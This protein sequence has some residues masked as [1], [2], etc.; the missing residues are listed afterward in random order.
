MKNQT[1]MI[2]LTL[3][4]G[5]FVN[6]LFAK[7]DV[8]VK[9]SNSNRLELQINSQDFSFK[10]S[11]YPD[12]QSYLKI[13]PNTGQLL[14][15]QPDLPQSGRW[16]IV[17]NGAEIALSW[18]KKSEPLIYDNISLAPVQPQ[19][20]DKSEAEIPPFTI[21]R[22]LYSRNS[23]FP[24]KIAHIERRVIKNG[25]EYALL[26]ISPFQYNP[27][28]KILKFYP[29]LEL[30]ID[31]V[32]GEKAQIVADKFASTLNNNIAISKDQQRRTDRQTG[33]DMLIVT[34]TEFALAAENLANWK[35]Q[36]GLKTL[37]VTTSEIGHTASA[38]ESY[39]DDSCATWDLVPGYLLLL[40]DAEFIPT[41]YVNEHPYSDGNQGF[42][43]ADI[44]YADLQDDLIADMAYGRIP[45]DTAAEADSVVAQIIRYEKDPPQEA[46]FYENAI[47]AAYFQEQDGGNGIAERR[48]A[49]TA[50]DFR[51]FLQTE[52]S[53]SVERIYVTDN[54][55]DPLYWNDGP[56]VFEN[57]EA[58]EPL[59]PEL[60]RPFFAWDGDY[61]AISS[62]VNLGKFMLL[63][64]DH[65][66]RQGW[67]DPY[68][69]VNN[70]SQLSN[71]DLPPIVWSINCET[72]WFDNETDAPSCGTANSSESFTEAWLRHLTAGS[73]GVFAATRVSYSGNNDRLVWG[74]L[75]A[76]WPQ[77][78]NWTGADYPQHTGLSRMGDVM[79]YGKE[80]LM[81]SYTWGDDVLLATMEEFSYFGDP[82]MRMYTELPQTIVATHDP[83]ITFG[84]QEFLVEANVEGAL[85]TLVYQ[86]EIISSGYVE[87][88]EVLLELDVLED[89][90]QAILTLSGHNLR[91]YQADIFVEPEGAYLT[92][93]LNEIVEQGDYID[94][95]WQSWDILDF[96]IQLN[97]IGSESSGDLEL[98][99]LSNN[100]FVEILE[101]DATNTSLSPGSQSTIN[102]AFKVRLLE[103][104]AD[105]TQISLQ[106]QIENDQQQWTDQI[107]FLARAANLVQ[108]DYQLESDNANSVFSP[109]S[110]GEIYFQLQN[111][112]SGYAYDVE[113]A[114]ISENELVEIFGGEY[115]SSLAPGEV[116][117]SEQAFEIS[118]DQDFPIDTYLDV[119]Y[120]Q[121]DLAGLVFETENQI[122]I[123]VLL[124]DFETEND[125][126][127][128]ALTD[129]YGNQWHLSEIANI[130]IDGGKAYKFGSSETDNY[131]TLQHGALYTPEIQLDAGSFLRFW[132]KMNVGHQT[133]E[134]SWDGGLLE[135]SVEG[136]EFE[137]IYPISG[138]PNSLLNLPSSPF[139]ADTEFFSGHFD[140]RQV[141]FD[142][143]EY[144]GTAVV[145]FVFGSANMQTSEGWYIDDLRFGS[146]LVTSSQESQ[147]PPAEYRARNFPN[148]FVAASSS[149]RQGGTTIEFNLPDPQ[150]ELTKLTIF[151]L[152]GQVVKNFT[153]QVE[154]ARNTTY[155][156]AWAGDDQ[157]GKFVGSGIYFYK[158]SS[159][160][161]SS[162]HKMMM[163]K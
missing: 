5:L 24:A 138:Y 116:Y 124:Y 140:W 142:L 68:F 75:N 137:Q 63:H 95:S 70:V 36:L 147:T 150:S 123:G 61:A 103:G 13:L 37:V 31:F 41:H 128:E 162:I 19:R 141:E 83:V 120:T 30:Q 15:G 27:Q 132:H 64:R 97:N 129:G 53:Y 73:V 154:Q 85:A 127:S 99:L 65:G 56:Y 118:L 104:I 149:T 6:I 92:A 66:W 80:Y 28:T 94:N 69:N 16:I 43:A 161:F 88:G 60:Q 62:S 58:A 42:T 49:K 157:S 14:P 113:T 77:F 114:L 40:G 2:A 35:R 26:K 163:I 156:I 29:N 125:W 110:S 76:I 158:I 111:I 86:N 131:A 126:F 134:I 145:R 139:A 102:S 57:D 4:L 136:A 93:E 59:P 45:I 112:G 55:T 39:I 121:T 160:K 23:W 50:E 148:P 71:T 122:L 22:S 152:K 52:N 12:K 9:Q 82:A 7:T 17:P 91:T 108:T 133:N 67:G 146:T 1:K 155:R 117:S 101:A 38:I 90:G 87:S 106:V 25:Q 119:Q 143:S 44:Y 51:N 96:D 21:D 100:D 144:S 48:F 151:N 20:R 54:S 3:M 159:G 74:M 84:S 153:I 130:T 33:Y 79:N 105:S 46:S 109:G 115:I 89:I 34:D 135:I 72:G 32:G 81:T 78:L 107:E 98:S 47:A 8:M 10:D 18:Q 11:P